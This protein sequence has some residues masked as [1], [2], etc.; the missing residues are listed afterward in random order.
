MFSF[1]G[2]LLNKESS[3]KLAIYKLGSWL[4]IS[5]AKWNLFVTVYSFLDKSAKNGSKDFTSL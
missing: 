2:V 1:I 3:S 4:Q 5:S